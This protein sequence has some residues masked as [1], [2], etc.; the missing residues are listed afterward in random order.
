IAEVPEATPDDV[1]RAVGAARRAFDDGEWARLTGGE[2]GRALYRVAALMRERA[3]ELATLESLDTGKPITLSRII[4]VNGAASALEYYGSLVMSLEGATRST[5]A[6]TF[7]YTLREP[8]GVVGAITPFN[9]PLILSM[10]KIAP[11]LAA[12]NTIVHKPAEET[13]L[14]ALAMGELF[15]D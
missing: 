12:G 10:S 9:F 15:A 5:A 11:A 14:T 1:D 13:P 2:R 3:D 6:P 4:D 8:L 7:S